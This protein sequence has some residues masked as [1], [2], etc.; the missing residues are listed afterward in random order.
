MSEILIVGNVL[1]DVYL[2]L[3]ERRDSFEE[4]ENGVFWMNLGFNG[5]G[6]NFFGASTSVFRSGSDLGSSGE[7]W[8]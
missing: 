1:K 5:E 2:R 7:I 8:D 3:D 4:D 6:H